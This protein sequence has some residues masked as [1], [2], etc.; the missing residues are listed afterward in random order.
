M[1]MDALRLVVSIAVCQ[2]ASLIG[3]KYTIQSIIWYAGLAKPAFN[4]ANDAFYPVWTLLYTL[5]G[6]S[7][8]LIWRQPDQKDKRFALGFF[9]AQLVL[10]IMWSWVFFELQ[11]PFVAFIEIILLEAAVL[12]TAFYFY[13]LSKW[14]GILMIPYFFRVGYEAVLNYFIWIMNP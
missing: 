11:A 4:P 9:F 13:R 3:A 1:A 7:L 6:I 14:A 5:M 12:A 10:N 2:I 8:F